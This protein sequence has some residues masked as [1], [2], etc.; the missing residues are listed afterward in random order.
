[1]RALRTNEQGSALVV[2]MAVLGLVSVM[3]GTLWTLGVQFGQA[4]GNDRDGIRA[5]AAADA[6]MR[7]ARYR[8][9]ATGAPSAQ[10]F[11]TQGV[12]ADAGG[13]CPG[14]TD[15]QGNGTSS[16]YYVS[17]V[18]SASSPCAGLYVQPVNGTPVPQRCITSIGTAHGITRRVQ[19]RVAAYAANP[20]FPVNG[21][22]ALSSF[23]TSG[24][25][26][27]TGDIGSNGNISQ[28]GSPSDGGNV[29][30]VPPASASCGSCTRVS[31]ATRFSVPPP[32]ASTY[33]ATAASNGNAAIAWPSGVYTPSTR[34][35]SASGTVGSAASP[36]VIPSG[37][38]NFCRFQFSNTTYLTLAPGARVQI[39]IDSPYRAGSG[40]PN[41]TGDINVTGQMSFNNPSGD[42]ANLLID[43]YGNPSVN[44]SPPSGS[45]TVIKFN[46]VLNASSSPFAAQLFAPN[47][48]FT[49]TNTFSMVGPVT[50]YSFTSSNTSSFGAGSAGA[51]SGGKPTYFLAGWRQCSSAV[52]GPDPAAGC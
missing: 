38:Y 26:S 29:Y 15:D 32:D 3:I 44:A 12:E 49:T 9:N 28:S 11:T 17:P 21:I 41:G 25:F 19:A 43:V 8:L 20:W 18:L 14:Q 13:I 51:G 1:M 35:V 23:T 2:A 22:T 34:V 5:F 31:Q 37:T 6:G 4:A 36:I 48:S 10:C 45:P 42:P 52:T 30:Y 27:T 40:C 39:Y 46:N 33:Q 47:S 16:T 7:G 24:T 50:S